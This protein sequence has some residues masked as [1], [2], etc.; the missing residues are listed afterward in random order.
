MYHLRK[1]GAELERILPHFPIQEHLIVLHLVGVQD[2]GR[3]ASFDFTAVDPGASLH[4][5]EER[6]GSS[7][8]KQSPDMVI[9]P[10]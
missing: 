7:S 1:T 4:M 8:A 3:T 9:L 5:H 2:A 10:S 6:S